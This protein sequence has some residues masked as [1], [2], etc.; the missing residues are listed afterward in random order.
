[1]KIFFPKTSLL[2][3]DAVDKLFYRAD[4]FKDVVII[5]D[6]QRCVSFI[7]AD[8]SQHDVSKKKLK[9]KVRSLVF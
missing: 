2:S 4:S 8:V 5:K 7:K 3:L 9:K 6:V 1:M